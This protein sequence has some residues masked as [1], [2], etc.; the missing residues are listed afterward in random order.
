MEIDAYLPKPVRQ[1]QLYDSIA[2]VMSQAPQAD[3]PA[4]VK[5]HRMVEAQTT[6]QAKV[7]LAEDNIVNQKVT[8]RMLEKLGCRV[9]AVANGLEVLEALKHIPYDLVLMDCQMPEMDGYIAT[10]AIREQEAATGAHL[11]IIAMT[12]NAMLGD[13]E[14]CLQAGM[15]AY[16]SKPMKS[17]QLFEVLRMWTAQPD[18]ASPD[19]IEPEE[20]PVSTQT[21]THSPSILNMEIFNALHD[22][23]ERRD[24]AFVRDL[25][26][27]FV[28]DAHVYITTLYASIDSGDAETLKKT[29]SRLKTSSAHIGAIGLATCCQSLELLGPSA[30]LQQ[31][32]PVVEQLEVHFIQVRQSLNRIVN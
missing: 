4:S 32:L 21:E 30:S 24:P 31:V 20:T 7:L 28:R 22:Q 17:D 1:S 2:S 9:D 19:A 27:T 12:A 11:P 26:D 23:D 3:P 5:R 29:A 14:R 18:T 10:R 8:V 13:R 16:I 25:V 6:P 15:D